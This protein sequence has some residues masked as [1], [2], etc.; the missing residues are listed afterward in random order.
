[1]KR[2]KLFSNSSSLLTNWIHSGKCSKSSTDDKPTS[3]ICDEEHTPAPNNDVDG[4]G[5]NMANRIQDC[6]PPDTAST[7]SASIWYSNRLIF[8]G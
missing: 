4:I 8:C 2:T 1:M 7:R 5:D 6:F 3:K